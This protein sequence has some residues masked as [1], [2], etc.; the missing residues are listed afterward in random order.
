M[1][2]NAAPES[3]PK[4]V[5][6]KTSTKKKSMPLQSGND[7]MSQFVVATGM[8]YCMPAAANRQQ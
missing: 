2:A 3:W 1:G 8:N 5:P 4:P 6:W 7:M